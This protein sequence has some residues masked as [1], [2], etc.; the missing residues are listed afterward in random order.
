MILDMD[1]TGSFKTAIIIANQLQTGSR[2][3]VAAGSRQFLTG[4]KI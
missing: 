2:V 3:Q 4:A 1:G